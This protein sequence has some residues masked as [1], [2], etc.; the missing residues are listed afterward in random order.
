MISVLFAGCII[1]SKF[2]RSVALISM[3]CQENTERIVEAMVC[4]TGRNG[5]I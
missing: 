1:I 3:I 2:I 5:D 4:I